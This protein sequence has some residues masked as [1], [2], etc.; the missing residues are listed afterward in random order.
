VVHD[1]AKVGARQTFITS[2]RH[3]VIT[4]SRQRLVRALT[5][6]TIGRTFQNLMPFHSAFHC[7]LSAR[8][9][10][11]ML[12]QRG[13]ILLRSSLW[14]TMGTCG[15]YTERE[16]ERGREGERERERRTDTHTCTSARERARAHTHEWHTHTHSCIC[17][18]T[19]IHM[20][21]YIH[22]YIYTHTNV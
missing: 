6:I 14:I 1:N 3:H 21:V 20:Y 8:I 4:S 12:S 17:V 11:V 18:Y 22:T 2:S 16:R 7:D 15:F 19:Y 9:C 10:S 5:P 13:A